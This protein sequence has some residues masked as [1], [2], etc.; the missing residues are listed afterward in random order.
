MDKR[1]KV[2]VLGVVVLLSVLIALLAN[3]LISKTKIKE[4]PT[5]PKVE[6]VSKKESDIS[7]S[8]GKD[9]SSLRDLDKSSISKRIQV[10]NKTYGLGIKDTT[11]SSLDWK[12]SGVVVTDSV[13]GFE[14]IT[15]YYGTLLGFTSR[16]TLSDETLK[17]VSKSF[18]TISLGDGRVLYLGSITNG[19]VNKDKPLIKVNQLTTSNIPKDTDV[20][21]EKLPSIWKGLGV[22]EDNLKFSSF[23]KSPSGVDLAEY[24]NKEGDYLYYSLYSVPSDEGQSIRGKFFGIMKNKYD[25]KITDLFVKNVAQFGIFEVKG[26]GILWITY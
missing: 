16:S 4:E 19:L 13:G 14:F 18:S 20:E 17:K 8:F 26:G 11:V 21:L 22:S 2:F 6:H 24:K 15:D 1:I 10:F 3:F 12:S 23:V 25:S 7:V 9:I 5:K